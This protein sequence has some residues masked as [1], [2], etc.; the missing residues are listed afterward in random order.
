MANHLSKQEY[1]DL[2]NDISCGEKSITVTRS[3]SRHF[4]LHV[5]TGNVRDLTS[6]SVIGSKILVLGLL[7]TSVALM[8]GC[9]GLLINEFP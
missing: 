5:G 1:T 6:Q 9:L 2:V 7:I 3:H 4:Y 8:L